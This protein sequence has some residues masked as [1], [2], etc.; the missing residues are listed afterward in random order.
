M[1]IVGGVLKIEENLVTQQ[2]ITMAIRQGKLRLCC[3]YKIQNQKRILW[4]KR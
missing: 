2:P 3:V 1:I 4:K